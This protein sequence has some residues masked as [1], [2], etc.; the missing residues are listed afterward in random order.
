MCLA[1]LYIS[2]TTA[3]NQELRQCLAYFF[4]VYSYSS[5]I[6][7]SRVQSVCPVYSSFSFLADFLKIFMST[8]DYALRLHEDLDDDQEM[9]A[10][11]QLGLLMVD[12]TNPQKAAE[13][14]VL[15]VS[16]TMYRKVT[17]LYSSVNQDLIKPTHVNLAVDIL[18]ALYDSDRTVDEQKTLLQLLGQL[19]MAPDLDLRSI[20]KLNILV[21]Y[22][23]EV[24]FVLFL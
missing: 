24:N 6:N 16:L 23:E 19:H 20:Q 11:Y 5:P 4:P 2:P 7:Q 3:N 12:W 8:F 14:S 15:R 17:F 13:M 21:T 1:L 18:I 10:P 9:I 22:H